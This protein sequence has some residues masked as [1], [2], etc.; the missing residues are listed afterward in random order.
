MSIKGGGVTEQTNQRFHLAALSVSWASDP[1]YGDGNSIDGFPFLD[2]GVTA[3]N[4]RDKKISG[5]PMNYPKM[6]TLP[7]QTVQ[8][9]PMFE[10]RKYKYDPFFLCYSL[11]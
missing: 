10:W 5:R 4:V 2:A 3:A 6:D 7:F 9:V 1:K 8:Y 11:D